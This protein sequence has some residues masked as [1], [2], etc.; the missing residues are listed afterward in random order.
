MIDLN[1][2]VRKF[3]V[4]DGDAFRL[5]QFD[6]GETCGLDIEKDEAKQL[7]QAGVKRLRELQERLYARKQWSVLI[8]LQAMDTAGK[9]GAIEHVMSGV[10]PQ[11]CTVH[12]FKQPSADE[13]A[14]DF[15]W[16]AGCRLPARGHIGVFNRSYY[17]ETL[18]VRV[19]ENL[20]RA[21]GLPQQLVDKDIWKKRF[22]SIREFEKHL[23]RNGVVILKFFL[24]VSKDEQRRRLLARIDEPDKNWKF[25]AADMA[26]RRYWDDYQDAYQQMIA[27]TATRKAPWCVAPADNKWFTR[28]V[29][30]ATIID[31]LGKLD[32]DFPEVDDAA[33][34]AMA[35]AR[36]QLLAED[37]ADAN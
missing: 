14:H 35:E 22:K 5:K 30:A 4:T 18:V 29:V 15:L 24:N 12:S 19:H 6:P 31:T 27:H 23:T 1:E 8:V 28:I 7:L 25:S 20:L 10:N 17:E 33:R 9:D 11:G 36:A 2:I 13:L 32:L 34:Q 21:E 3:R 26:E 16:R 37:G